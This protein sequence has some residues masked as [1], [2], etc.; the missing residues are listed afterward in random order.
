[1]ARRSGESG[2]PPGSE[3]KLHRSCRTASVP[4]AGPLERQLAEDVSARAV[5]AVDV[6]ERSLVADDRAAGPDREGLRRGR[7][8]RERDDEQQRG[9]ESEAAGAKARAKRLIR[10]GG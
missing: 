8:G 5:E 1:M 7:R 10:P 4:R 2:A 3:K 6:D 9:E